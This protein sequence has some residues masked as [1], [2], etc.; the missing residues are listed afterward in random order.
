MVDLKNLKTGSILSESSFFIVKNVKQ[1]SI[2]VTDDYNNEL[3]IGNPYVEKI[4][5]SA[6]CFSSEENKTK[7]ELAEIF[8]NS[9]RIAM[10]V[11]YFKQ[12]KTKT[13]KAYIAEVDAA[14]NKIQNAKVSEVEGLLRDLITNP[15]LDYTPG[16]LRVM[17]GR[18]YGEI[19]DL[20]R[21]AFI[22]MEEQNTNSN[23]DTRKKLV[24][25]RT[26]QYIIVNNV[27]YLLKN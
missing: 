10:T 27:K 11:A 2:V 1:D 7:T 12:D 13:K 4:L 9:P 19:D 16:E 25:P 23:F 21:I 14:V 20:G 5:N 18:H 8:I 22:D 15:I 26:I 24:D 6:D 17:K 3:I